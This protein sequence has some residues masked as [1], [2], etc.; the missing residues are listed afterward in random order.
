[1]KKK[2]LSRRILAAFLSV[3][4]VALMLPF[5]L[6]TASAASGLTSTTV[7]GN[8]AVSGV[9]WTPGY[10]GSHSHKGGE[11]WKEVPASYSGD[12]RV[13][14]VIV[15]PEAGTTIRF[16]EYCNG[17]SLNQ[18]IFVLSSWK[19]E[20]GQWV[21]DPSGVELAANPAINTVDPHNYTL[22]IQYYEKSTKTMFYTYTTTRPNEALRFTIYGQTA[23]GWLGEGEGP[24][25]YAYK[26]SFSNGTLEGLQWFPGIVGAANQT[27]YGYQN[28]VVDFPFEGSRYHYS[29]PVIVPKAGT[30]ITFT[31]P[32]STYQV[33]NNQ[34]T[35]SAWTRG[36][37]GLLDFLY[38]VNGG[39]GATYTYTTTYDN[40]ILRFLMNTYGGD[41]VGNTVPDAQITYAE[42]SGNKGTLALAGY[43]PDNLGLVQTVYWQTGLI[44]DSNTLGT[45]IAPA[46]NCFYAYSSVVP[47]YGKGVTVSYTDNGPDNS[48]AGGSHVFAF[49][50]DIDGSAVDPTLT[51]IKGNDP[52][53]YTDS[54][55]GRTYSYTTT[56]DIT[57]MRFSYRSGARPTIFPIVYATDSK[58]MVYAEELEGLNVLIMGDSIMDVRSM[59][60]DW[61]D[62]EA[63]G[64]GSYNEADRQFLMQTA[65]KYNW[66]SINYGISG[67]TLSNFDTTANPMCERIQN[68]QKDLVP[69]LIILEGSSND[70]N[71]NAPQGELDSTDT[72]TLCGGFNVTLDYLL[73]TYPNA[74]IICTS[75]WNYGD[76]SF[77]WDKGD[78]NGTRLDYAMKI[79][80]L[81]AARNSSRVK[82][83]EFYNRDVVPG[84][85]SDDTFVKLYGM[86]DTDRSHL[87]AK[88][89][90]L[91]VPGFEYQV[92]RLYSEY[93]E[94]KADEEQSSVVFQT[95]AGVLL[96]AV[97]TAAAGS[98]TIPTVPASSAGD[99]QFVGWKGSVNGEETFLTPTGTFSYNAGD[100]AVFTPVYV[101]ITSTG[102]PSVR[103][104]TGSTGMRFTTNIPLTDWAKI[105]DY[106][107]RGTLIVP[108]YYVDRVGGTL[109]HAALDA[110]GAQRIDVE[111]GAWYT[112]TDTVGTF[113]GSIA[114]IKTKN[115]TLR[116]TGLGYVKITYT[117]GTEAYF[118][119][120]D[121]ASAIR[122]V[123]TIAYEAMND[124]SDEQDDFYTNEIIPGSYSPY[125]AT[126][127]EI[128]KNFIRPVIALTGTATVNGAVLTSSDAYVQEGLSL[129]V[130]LAGDG[131][132]SGDTVVDAKWETYAPLLGDAAKTATGVWVISNS[133][134]EFDLNALC[135]VVLDGA[136]QNWVYYEA[137]RVILVA[138]ST[139]SDFY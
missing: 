112:K 17:A 88:G 67:S 139:Y 77:N 53:Y 29:M 57:Y 97:N 107:Q 6:L 2:H 115:H 66:K 51:P 114:N 40:E 76:N 68:M 99:G 90:D 4:T 121:A 56:K 20:N 28:A 98:L 30:T 117:N 61:K 27:T 32:T 31:D 85:V 69:D 5:A 105:A 108:E 38:G 65:A 54:A 33:G 12:F 129:A 125:N 89:M 60:A 35:I 34:Y 16:S 109:T 138:F 95:Q 78:G 120:T 135:G 39:T 133:A 102:E 52:T 94:N 75:V 86:S 71:V 104:T 111:T 55:A 23:N 87:N 15:V 93:L 45:Y 119:A 73:E 103:F 72:K 74:L 14:N 63:G 8:G 62:A 1:M 24:T 42:N 36:R 50:T 137:E 127:I 64:K 91:M 70:Y 19:Q 131:D 84:Y 37:D 46:D 49:Y 7:Q 96:S 82:F 43:Q 10:I 136:T 59:W 58:A 9:T 101:S 21:I 113:A 44:D 126:Q 123:Y 100:N 13:S 110:H 118:Y 11:A 22:G 79:A 122:A 130:V 3:L 80:D 41:N 132:E 116:F 47:V 26:A 83:I 18:N 134:G 25:V 48:Y 106:A 81:V 124:R 128:L 92:A